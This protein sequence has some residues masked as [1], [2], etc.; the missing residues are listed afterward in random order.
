MKT[1]IATPKDIQETHKFHVIDAEG[2]V[3]GRLASTVAKLL[4][5]KHKP[6][7]TPFLDTGDHVIIVNADKVKLT[8]T[9]LDKK[10]VIYH[11]LH[12]G[13]LRRKLLRT[14]MEEK[15]TQ[16]I[17]KAIWGMLPKNR[18]GRKMLKKLRV[19]KGPRSS[20]C[21]S[22][23]NPIRNEIIIRSNQNNG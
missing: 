16:V 20:S 4:T 8:G 14:A 21:G 2:L 7:Y 17:E 13:G 5:G 10:E 6:I 19:Y 12:P 18:L 23:T 22:K 3:L 9:K 11:T 1:H 15:P